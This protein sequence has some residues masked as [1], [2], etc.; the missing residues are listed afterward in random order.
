MA[1]W[2]V[3]FAILLAVGIAL[4]VWGV[5]QFHKDRTWIKGSKVTYGKIVEVLR[6][7]TDVNDIRN[8][9]V[10]VEYEVCNIKYKTSIGYTPLM[11]E[12]KRV[13]IHYMPL[14]PE[15][16]TYLKSHRW[17]MWATFAGAA[18]DLFFCGF[19]GWLIF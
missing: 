7:Y 19:I 2:Y 10:E 17:F 3:L 8:V 18:I 15:N 4:L 5:F 11:Q 13:K 12:G 6:G 1:H 9:S 16:C 14:D